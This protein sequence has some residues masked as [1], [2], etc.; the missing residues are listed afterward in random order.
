MAV[1]IPSS[2]IAATNGPV[3]RMLV[4][5]FT[6]TELPV[7]LSNQD[8]LRFAPDGTL[9]ALGYDG[10]VWRLRDTD[11]DGLED[12]AEPFWDRPTLSVPVGM[13][14]TTQGLYVASHGKVSL[15]RDT[16]GD[17]RADTEEIVVSDWPATDGTSGGVDAAALTLDPAGNIYF[18]LL[19]AD[20]SNAY[21][22]RK[23]KDLRPEDKAWLAANGRAAEGD[24][25]EEVSLYDIASRRGTIQRFSPRSKNLA[26]IATGIRV[27]YALAFNRAGD[28]F[29]TDQEGE[30]WMPDG[31]P[32]DELNHIVIGRN[33]GFPPRHDRW[34]PDIV[35]EPPV[36]AFG[37]QHQSTCGLVF[38]E[39]RAALN[40][41]AATRSAA[42]SAPFTT[43]LPAPPVPVPRSR[44]KAPHAPPAPP[45]PPGSNGDAPV[46]VH[47]PL[48]AAPAQGLFGP[49]AWEGDA[50]VAGESRGKIWRTRLVKTPRGYV[51]KSQLI[52]RLSMLT[53]DLAISPKGDLYVCCHSGPPD[54]GTGPKGD[55]KI[56]KISYTDAKA[57]QPVAVW[58]ATPT[59]VRVAFDRPLEAAPAGASTPSIEFGEYVR[60]AD[61]FETLKPP[62]AVVG[63]Q[64]ATPRGHLAVH[65]TRLEDNG[66]TLVIGTDPHPLAVTYA[67]RLPGVKAAGEPG[68]GA[69]LDLDYDLSGVEAALT[70]PGKP[71]RRLWQPHPDAE[72]A[73]ALIRGS[74]AHDAFRAA[75]DGLGMAITAKAYLP[76]GLHQFVRQSPE[77]QASNPVFDFIWKVS[78]PDMTASPQE[79]G[80]RI[81]ATSTSTSRPG[82][83]PRIA[84]RTLPAT[85]WA[86]VPLAWF[87]VPWAP[88][89]AGSSGTDSRAT[90]AVTGDWENGR[91]HFFGDKLQCA[92]CHR[93]RGEGATVGP[94][95]SNLVHRDATSVLRDIRD[96]D[97]TLHPDHVTYLAVL[98]NGVTVTGFVRSSTDDA[99]RLTDAT[100]KDTTIPRADLQDLHPTGRSLMPTGLLNSLKP[101]EVDDLMTFLLKEPPTRTKAEVEPI[102][103]RP[104]TNVGSPK[105][106]IVLVAS[107]QD[108]GP[109]QHDYP[110]WQTKWHR[111]LGTLPDVN[112]A[113]AWEW[114]SA[115]QFAD[116]DVLVF[117]FWNHDWSA[118][119]YAQVDAYQQRGG[120]VVVLHSATIAD[121]E[122]EK[123]AE[124]IGLSAQP[125]TVKYRHTAFDLHLD[126]KHPLTRGLPEWLPFLDEPY[127]P[128]IGD[129]ARITVLATAAM[130][131][132]DRPLV[133]TFQRGQGR[134]FASILGHYFWTLDDPLWRVLCLRG[135]AWAGGRDADS[136]TALATVEAAVK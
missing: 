57:P 49:A 42:L 131:G 3:V 58:P 68:A 95:L 105:L 15:L 97:A 63:Q 16:D 102:L 88:A 104:T 64:A 38:N 28:L 106:R 117:Y 34:L 2:S 30:T 45:F 135:I 7:H 71:D 56:F 44:K 29:N 111:L 37:P 55:G 32:L 75:R 108:H 43:P 101:S 17:G 13:A 67:L 11:G 40:A 51:G 107:K 116:A 62:Y 27:P 14:W 98:K 80:L 12:T 120:G 52:A 50:F 61:R 128:M 65:R 33:Y 69:T 94:D 129:P 119:R 134:V 90:S 74:A 89:A 136:L 114:P 21:R 60:A 110:A 91:G 113:T 132:A 83:A 112:I 22:L 78:P 72:V 103:K 123:L 87:R 46:P 53:V 19:V 35:S 77:T 79:T 127:W 100:G 26:T 5:G 4:P 66:R 39:P 23:R 124:R 48:P 36:V 70:S 8:N 41:D 93:I 122:P 96:P 118:A 1:S 20:Y 84:F 121:T 86:N 9:T 82:P 54:W 25:E 126:P 47:V 31:N 115:A 85:N 109:G 59:E 133:W 24:P 81:E 125:A 73:D 10:R 6:V 76:A 92:K 18:G 130:D 99:V